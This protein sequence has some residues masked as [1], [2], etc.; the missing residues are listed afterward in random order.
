VQQVVG[1]LRL[2]ERE[3]RLVVRSQ[4]HLPHHGEL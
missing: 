4:D 3:W 1:F 2:R